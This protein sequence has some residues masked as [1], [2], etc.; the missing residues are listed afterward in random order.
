[1]ALLCMVAYASSYAHIFADAVA[2]S[3]TA[4]LVVLPVLALLIA[5]GYRTTSHG[6]G[7]GESDWIVA[8]LIGILGL[9]AIYL[10]IGRMPT[11]SA[12]WR[13]ESLAV[14]VWAVCCV[15]ILFGMRHALTMWSLWLF[16][17]CFATPV[18]YL[19]ATAALGGTPIDGAIVAAAIGAVAVFLAT[20]TLAM[21]R[22][23]AA[24]AIS[25]AASAPLVVNCASW[26][27]PTIIVAAGVIPV[28]SVIGARLTP[29]SRSADPTER[30]I[31]AAMPHR[32]VRTV[33]VL[34]VGTAILAA[35][36]LHQH[37]AAAPRT[38]P[39]DWTARSGL[40]RIASYDF[41]TKFAG[42]D[43]TLVRFAAPDQKGMP[44]AAVDVL[45]TPSEAVLADLSDVVWYP[46]A[47]P[48][49][50]RAVAASA[51][52]PAGTRVLHSDADAAA[53]AR[54]VDW[55][56]LT[57]TQRAGSLFQRVTVIVSQSLSGD[58]APPT[59]QPPDALDASVGSWLWLSRQRPQGLD[60]VDPLVSQR[61][62]TLTAAVSAV[63]DSPSPGGSHRRD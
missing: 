5:A 34:A 16:L 17:A 1:M 33:G 6:V 63:S 35:A 47:R 12:W 41:V 44:A 38:I 27:L 14:L 55:Y 31:S 25:L 43:S 39:T 15:I 54:G 51:G 45:S 3:R 24:T 46:A 13:L 26:F 37:D 32:S 30:P 9:A 62:A 57:W 18:P 4:Y 7:D 59:P 50:Y 52:I 53:D 48:V 49:S 8:A 19:A 61:A 29:N 60:H 20:R 42:P 21:R 22:R 58:Q 2:G 28:L 10:L 11:L 40:S 56:A 36:G 23:L